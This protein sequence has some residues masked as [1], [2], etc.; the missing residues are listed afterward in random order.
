MPLQKYVLGGVSGLSTIFVSI[1]S[2]LN[3][4]HLLNFHGFIVNLNIKI[5][6]IIVLP[7]LLFHFPVLVLDLP[8][9]Y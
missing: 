4:Y 6:K 5:I 2:F 3:K 8:V 9:C 7:L 1:C